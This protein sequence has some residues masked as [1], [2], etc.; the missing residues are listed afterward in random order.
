MKEEKIQGG[1]LLVYPGIILPACGTDRRFVRKDCYGFLPSIQLC[2]CYDRLGDHRRAWH[3]HLKSQKLKPEH[4][5]VRQNQTY[6]EHKLNVR[7]K[8]QPSAL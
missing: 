7:R 5:S 8:G 2:V 4:P 3:Y 6:F 1:C